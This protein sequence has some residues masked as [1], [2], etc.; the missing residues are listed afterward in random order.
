MSA[1]SGATIKGA[2]W[3]L[4]PALSLA[5]DWLARLGLDAPSIAA[6]VRREHVALHA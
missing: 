1:V 3:L 5:A 4:A 6:F 2:S